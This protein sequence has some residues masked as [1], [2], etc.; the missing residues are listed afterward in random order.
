MLRRGRKR[1][2]YH[3]G[4]NFPSALAP[5]AILLLLSL[6][7]RI[8]DYGVTEERY[9]GVVAG[10][11]IFAWALVYIVRRRAGI[12]WIPSS[13]AVICLLVAFGPWSA[14]AVSKMSQLHR[15]TAILKA[16]GL[17]AEGHAQPA[18]RSIQI[19]KKK[20]EQL[21]S[22]LTYLLAMHGGSVVRPIFAT[23]LDTAR[24]GQSES[25][26]AIIGALHIK[27]R[28]QQA[29]LIV[30]SDMKTG[31]PIDGFHRL[32]RFEISRKESWHPEQ[33]DDISLGLDQGLLKCA[34]A[35]APA[36]Q[37]VPVPNSFFESDAT[38]YANV[39]PLKLT[40]DFQHGPRQF[41]LV[42]E[43]LSVVRDDEDV[44]INNCAG[45]L[46]EK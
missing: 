24:L 37:K 10:L 36:P 26:P 20:L 3:G 2:R 34:T 17:W 29:D 23:M 30:E 28:D 18:K 41:R 31:F 44:R 19:P 27:V 32:W 5:L 13:L 21:R 46:L 7:V 14:G 6:R 11:W 16:E 8:A 42:F 40:V 22:S 33:L 4:R 38:N 15:V 12:R 9:L 1:L 35:G 25:A 39:S 45:Y 43:R